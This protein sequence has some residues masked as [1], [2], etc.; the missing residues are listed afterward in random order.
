MGS[1]IVLAVVVII[2]AIVVRFVGDVAMFAVIAFAVGFAANELVTALKMREMR[3]MNDAV[4]SLSRA[5]AKDGNGNG[6]NNAKS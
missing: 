6:G 4:R 3:D 1:N 5:T 2:T